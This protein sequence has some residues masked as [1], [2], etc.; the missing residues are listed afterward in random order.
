MQYIRDIHMSP[1]DQVSSRS[2]RLLTARLAGCARSAR[3]YVGGR[4]TVHHAQTA[5]TP[6]Q[7]LTFT[8]QSIK[9]KLTSNFEEVTI[10][11]QQ[12]SVNDSVS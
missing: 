10:R 9:L 12:L 1:R 6:E 5:A 3:Q 2:Q 7:L 8:S 11:P 4:G